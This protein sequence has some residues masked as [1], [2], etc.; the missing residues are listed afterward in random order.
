MVFA[1]TAPLQIVMMAMNVP[2]MSVTIHSVL[3][4]TLPIQ[5]PP[6]L[7]TTCVPFILFVIAMVFAKIKLLSV[8]T[9]PLNAGLPSAVIPTL[10]CVFIISFLTIPLAMM[11]TLVPTP[12]FALAER[13]LVLPQLIVQQ[14]MNVTLPELAISSLG[15]A[16]IQRRQ[17]VLLVMIICSVQQL[18]PVSRVSVEACPTNAK[19]LLSII[20]ANTSLVMKTLISASFITT[21]MVFSVIQATVW[22]FALHKISVSMVLAWINTPLVL[23]ADLLW[24]NA[25]QLNSVKQQM[26]VLQTLQSQMERLVIKK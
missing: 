10:V 19:S 17:M 25:M 15:N 21:P 2:W 24:K 22:V 12:I 5:E 14:P 23:N 18:T 6:A 7:Q 20:N 11:A 3:V 4:L 9:L 26:I 8:V 13:A 1:M 16:Y